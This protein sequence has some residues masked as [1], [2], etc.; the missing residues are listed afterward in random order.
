MDKFDAE[1]T[2]TK[3]GVIQHVTIPVDVSYVV[4]DECEISDYVNEEIWHRL[5]MSLKDD[6]FEITNMEE[7]LS[8]MEAHEEWADE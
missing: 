3:D 2:I 8:D 7:L 4:A 5:G 1:V 6:E